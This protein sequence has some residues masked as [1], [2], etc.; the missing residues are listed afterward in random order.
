MA[1]VQENSG[2]ITNNMIKIVGKENV[3]SDFEERFCY[4][5]DATNVREYKR[6]AST[7]V[8]PRSTEDVSKIMQYAYKYSVPVVARSAGT[9]VSGGAIPLKSGIVLDFSKMDKILEINKDNLYVIAQPGVVVKTLQEEVSKSGLFYPPD[10]SSLAVSM[11]GG[12]LGMSSGGAR[13]FKYGTTKDYVINLEVVLADGRIINTGVDCAKNVTGYNLTQ[14]FVGSEGTLGIITKATLRLIPQPKSKKVLFAYFDTFEDTSNTVNNIISALITPSVIDIL[15]KNTLI[16]IEKYNPV[17]LLTDKE[18]ALL[19]EIDGE[20]E[21]IKKENEQIIEICKNNHSAYIKTAENEEEIEQ[22]WKTRRSSFGATAKLAPDVIT[23]DIVVPRTNIV[24]ALKGI[25]EICS[26]YNLKTC[27]MGHIGDGNIHPNFA[28]D[29]RNEEEFKNMQNAK[30]ELFNLAV[31]LSGTLS[32][33]HG[34]G[35]EKMPYIQKAISKDTLDVM[36]AIKKVLDDKNILNPGK[37]F[38]QV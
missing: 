8:F 34:I 10:P 1:L 13:S 17:G 18:A 36:R 22:I 38:E 12:S 23:E 15:D 28:L 4:S 14:L 24:K 16:T 25:R 3:L 27:I 20:E 6:I 33:E 21:T 26:K 7:V 19:I 35:C 32:G 2:S 37:I 11:L 30:E 31:S 29:L 5:V 9:S